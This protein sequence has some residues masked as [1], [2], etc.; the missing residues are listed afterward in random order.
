MSFDTVFEA[1]EVS[2][3]VQALPAKAFQ[4]L[5]LRK[6]NRAYTFIAINIRVEY[7]RFDLLLLSEKGELIRR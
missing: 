1:L 5:E 4:V 2:I 6:I 3:L 7:E